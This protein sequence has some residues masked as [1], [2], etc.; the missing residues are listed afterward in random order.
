MK[1]EEQKKDLFW[2]KDLVGKFYTAE[3]Y[4]MG[5]I[6]NIYLLTLH[7]CENLISDE[8][9]SLGANFQFESI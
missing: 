5:D 2:T 6:R 1:K 3:R 9:F 4:F 7:N 8:S